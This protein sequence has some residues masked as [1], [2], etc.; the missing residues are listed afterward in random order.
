MKWTLLV[1]TLTAAALAAPTGAAM[2]TARWGVKGPVQHPGTLKY[3][4]AAGE[5]MLLVFDLSGLPA[6]AKVYRARLFFFGVNWKERGFDI[7]PAERV[8]T[9]QGAKLTP[10]GERLRPVGPWYQWLAARSL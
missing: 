10:A 9:G 4:P 6:G 7:V 3:E 8:G 5:G 1:A 2:V